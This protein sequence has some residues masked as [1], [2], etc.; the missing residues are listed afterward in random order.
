MTLISNNIKRIE[1]WEVQE[2]ERNDMR[3][4][5]TTKGRSPLSPTDT[6]PVR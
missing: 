2:K 3:Q 5:P 1:I 4:Y 6:V